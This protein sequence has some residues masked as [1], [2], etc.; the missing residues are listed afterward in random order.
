MLDVDQDVKETCYMTRRGEDGH[1]EA[2]MVIEAV[3]KV[4]TPLCGVGL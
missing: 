1:G 3:D 4:V 2:K